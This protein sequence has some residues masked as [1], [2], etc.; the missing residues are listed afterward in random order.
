VSAGALASA[1]VGQSAVATTGTVDGL[2]QTTDMTRD[3]ISSLPPITVVASRPTDA[4]CSASSPTVDASD[5]IRQLPDDLSTDTP[6][7]GLM[8]CLSDEEP[9]PE[10]EAQVSVILINYNCN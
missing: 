9:D 4:A 3:F 6:A 2:G 10:I 8:S 7:T 5:W 1:V